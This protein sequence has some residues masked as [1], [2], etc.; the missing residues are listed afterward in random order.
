MNIAIYTFRTIISNLTSIDFHVKII[1][2]L[3]ANRT[4]YQQRI[5]RE[6]YPLLSYINKIY[7]MPVLASANTQPN[8][9]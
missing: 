6:N 8:A 4:I 9:S 1:L 5:N 3:P 2:L 7:F